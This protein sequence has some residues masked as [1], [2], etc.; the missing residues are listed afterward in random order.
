MGLRFRRSVK[1]AKGVRLNLG[2][3]GVS[4]SVGTRGLRQ[5]LHSSGRRTTSIGIPGAGVSYVRTTSAGKSRSRSGK[6]QQISAKGAVDTYNDL[7]AMLTGLHRQCSDTIDWQQVLESPAPF[8]LEQMGPRQSQALAKQEAYRSS[9]FDQ[10]FGRSNQKQIQLMAAVSMATKKDAAAY[11]AWKDEVTLARRILDMDSDAYRTAMVK[12]DMFSDL[13]EFISNVQFKFLENNSLM[14]EFKLAPDDVIPTHSLSL[15]KT[16][17]LSQRKI[18]KTAY[19][20]LVQDYVC[21]LSLRIAR[22]LLAI[23]PLQRVLMHV[24]ETKFNSATGHF[25]DQDILSVLFDRVTL[26]GLNWGLVDPAQAMQNF[27]HS[28]HFLKTAG[29]RPVKRLPQLL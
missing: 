12:M 26:E 13:Q 19:Y 7:I 4:V 17:K 27:Q 29:F 18:G 9:I 20:K 28:M 10:I 5:T 1:L 16:G 15:T 23:L 6:A 3:R 11:Q 25:E 21:G 8:N 2:K 24:V 22:E 14:L